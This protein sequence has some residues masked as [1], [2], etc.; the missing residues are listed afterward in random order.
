MYN[1]SFNLYLS[2]VTK[3]KRLLETILPF[4]NVNYSF[5]FNY[6]KDCQCLLMYEYLGYFHKIKVLYNVIWTIFTFSGKSRQV[7]NNMR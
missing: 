5:K 2:T 6:C 3:P 1:W 7:W 4:L